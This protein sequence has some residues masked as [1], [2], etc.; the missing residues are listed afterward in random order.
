[1]PHPRG[2]AP[3]PL[4]LHRPPQALRGRAVHAQLSARGL[5]SESFTTTALADMYFK[6][7]HPAD[8]LRVFDR[9]PGTASPGTRSSP[10]M[11]EE[12]GVRPTL[13]RSCPFS[14]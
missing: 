3:G 9:P 1:V 10:G 6:C 4:H 13:S 5:S 8:L 14:A 12:G 11:Q 7:H 2:R